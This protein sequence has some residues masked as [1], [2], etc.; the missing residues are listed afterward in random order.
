MLNNLPKFTVL[1]SC[2]SQKL[3]GPDHLINFYFILPG[4]I[5]NAAAT[6]SSFVQTFSLTVLFLLLL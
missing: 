5:L 2:K 1:I 6:C 3:G 4:L